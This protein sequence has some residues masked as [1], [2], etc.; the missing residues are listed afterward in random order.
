LSCD[1]IQTRSRYAPLIDT[2]HSHPQINIYART[3]KGA[4]NGT[5]QVYQLAPGLYMVDFRK[6]KGDEAEFYRLYRSVL[7]QC[8]NL[9]TKRQSIASPELDL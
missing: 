6:R 9:L 7:S 4:L 8:S 5:V 2:C 1:R 3:Q